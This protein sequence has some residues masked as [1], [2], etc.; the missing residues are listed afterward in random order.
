MISATKCDAV[1]TR[2]FHRD[3]VPI[4]IMMNLQV[5]AVDALICIKRD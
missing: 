1:M 3:A 5:H 4:S 2:L